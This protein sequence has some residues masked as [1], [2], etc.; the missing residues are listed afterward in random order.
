MKSVILHL[1]Q[2]IQAVKNILFFIIVFNIFLSIM[3]REKVD[4]LFAKSVHLQPLPI[5]NEFV[6]S[7]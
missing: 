2:L 4:L 7:G 6:L 3:I 1:K 5:E